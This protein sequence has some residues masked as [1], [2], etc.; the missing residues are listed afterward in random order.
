MKTAKGS[1]YSIAENVGGGK[2][3]QIRRFTM[4]SPKFYLTMLVI[5]EKAIGAGLKFAKV[6]LPN[7]ILHDIRQ[8]FLPL[9]FSAIQYY[10]LKSL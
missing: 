6:S 4:N 3:W 1:R 10:M 7:A 2:L 8:S 9:K 5:S